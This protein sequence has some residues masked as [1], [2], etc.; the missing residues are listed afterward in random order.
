[1]IDN[2]W[3]FGGQRVV[4]AIVCSDSRPI[5]RIHEITTLLHAMIVFSY[6][7]RDIIRSLLLRRMFRKPMSRCFLSIW[8]STLVFWFVQCHWDIAKVWNV[9]RSMLLFQNVSDY[10][11]LVGPVSYELT[12]RNGT[13]V[14]RSW[15][16]W[17]WDQT[18]WGIKHCF[19]L[20]CVV[21]RWCT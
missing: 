2:W 13:Y 4:N 10:W 6:W 7:C 11:V 15:D 3:S 18:L 19:T 12:G 5:S 21:I 9:Q 16:H 1:M 14:P 17:R 20:C 8:V